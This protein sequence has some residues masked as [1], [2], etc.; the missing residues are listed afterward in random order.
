MKYTPRQYTIKIFWILASPIRSVY[1]FIVRPK[2]LGVKC[3]IENEGAFLLVRINYGHR[4]WTVP[5]GGIHK[6]EASEVAA[7]RELKEETGVVTTEVKKIGE[8]VSTHQYKIDTVHVY[9]ARVP[10]RDFAI[11][12]FEIAEANWFTLEQIPNDRT[13]GVDRILAMNKD[14]Q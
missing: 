12:G 3:L 2:T 6:G 7:M 5:G 14:A 4:R 1:W 9:Y 8:Y 11:D 10:N 13:P